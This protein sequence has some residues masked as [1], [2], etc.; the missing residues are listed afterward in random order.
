MRD[1][2]R[3]GLFSKFLTAVATLSSVSEAIV[4]LK[5]PINLSDFAFL[6]FLPN[7]LAAVMGLA[8]PCTRAQP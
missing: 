6:G 2:S 4:L 3:A 7:G 5:K 1:C 8:S